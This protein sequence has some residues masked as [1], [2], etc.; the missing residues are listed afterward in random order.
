MHIPVELLEHCKEAEWTYH[1]PTLLTADPSMEATP[2]N[3]LHSASIFFEIPADE[4][5]YLH[6]QG[7]FSYGT[8]EFLPTTP[9]ST[10]SQDAEWSENWGGGVNGIQNQKI[11][12]EIDAKYRDPSVFS[13]ARVCQI[14]GEGVNYGVQGAEVP[15]PSVSG[16]STKSPIPDQ[17]GVV[18]WVSSIMSLP[19]F[20]F[21]DH[22]LCRLQKLA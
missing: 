12:V 3:Q 9:Q 13:W 18:I 15:T 19:S 1:Q 8:V 21:S 10:A 4:P 11:R 2:I 14:G 7:S 5:L 16:E 20:V 17:V 22:L 6:S